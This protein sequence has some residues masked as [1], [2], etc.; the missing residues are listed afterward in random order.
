MKFQQL[1]VSHPSAIRHW[2]NEGLIRSRRN[3]ENGLYRVFTS[4][5]L[6]KII[7]ISSLRKTVYFIESMKQLLDDLETQTM[8]PIERSFQ[9]ALKKLNDQLTLQYQGISRIDELYTKNGPERGHKNNLKL[10]NPAI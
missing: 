10:N 2:E 6:R 1:P 5:E 4:H 9:L 7:V 3:E 8:A